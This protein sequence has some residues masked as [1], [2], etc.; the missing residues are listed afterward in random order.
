[1]IEKLI[2]LNESK[3]WNAEDAVK[4]FIGLIFDSDSQKWLNKNGFVVENYENYIVNHYTSIDLDKI[5]YYRSSL[6]NGAFLYQFLVEKISENVFDIKSLLPVNKASLTKSL[7]ELQ[8]DLVDP[9]T[10]H[11]S[12]IRNYLLF[13]G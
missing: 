13:G 11:F 7:E 12:E 6:E 8:Q 1:M 10:F 5:Y 4:T 3:C 9:N 2:T